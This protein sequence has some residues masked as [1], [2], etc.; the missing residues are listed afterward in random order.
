MTKILKL[1]LNAS[2]MSHRLGD[3]SLACAR[4]YFGAA[5]AF[6]HGI[7]KIPPSEKWISFVS[8]LG[9]PLPEVFAWS[10]GFTE[11]IGGGLIA[12]GLATRVSS[13][14][15]I[16]TMLVAVVLGHAGDPFKKIE[17]G[18]C[19]LFASLLF[20]GLGAGRYSLDA[21]ISKRL[22]SNQG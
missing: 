12:L 5:M 13:F 8:E 14:F 15:L 9:F 21:I 22:K 3:L 19:Y 16:Q 4:I 2:P 11:L 10:A 20:L 6:A 1:L 18:L 17:L 7:K